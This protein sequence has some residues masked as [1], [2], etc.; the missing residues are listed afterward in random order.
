M[1]KCSSL[2]N[3]W[4]RLPS[5]T[6]ASIWTAFTIPI[7]G[8]LD[9]SSTDASFSRRDPSKERG[10]RFDRSITD[11]CL[12]PV[13]NNIAK[14]HDSLSSRL[15][16]SEAVLLAFLSLGNLWVL[17]ADRVWSS[18][19]FFPFLFIELSSLHI[20]MAKSSHRFWYRKAHDWIII[21]VYFLYK[22]APLPWM[23]YAPALSIGSLFQYKSKS[24]LHWGPKR[25]FCLIIKVSLWFSAC[26]L[27]AVITEWLRPE[28]LHDIEA[29]SSWS[30][31]LPRHSPSRHTIV[32]A[33]ITIACGWRSA[34]ALAFV[35]PTIDVFFRW[36]VSI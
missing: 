5:S 31:G 34:T 22:S 7:P 3:L 30:C 9:S 19:P 1:T 10:D 25:N 13:R 27:T 2:A 36:K 15:R 32:S 26:M 4:I 21:S 11:S 16:L 17:M 28:S 33:P 29:A 35:L 14:V 6:A 8:M 18:T 23:P 20:K 24:L 12:V